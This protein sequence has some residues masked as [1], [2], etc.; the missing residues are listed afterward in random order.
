MRDSSQIVTLARI[1]LVA[2]LCI[3]RLIAVVKNAS[4]IFCKVVM[5][6]TMKNQKETIRKI[7]THLNNE[8]ANGGFWLPN[9]QRPFVWKEEQIERLFDSLMRKYPIST[10]LAWRT[11]SAI[12]HRKVYRQL[13]LK[14]SFD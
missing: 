1:N 13:S 11:K 5:R 7:V 3:V 4:V 9:I 10:L 2:I 12:K 6:E 8:E 14:H